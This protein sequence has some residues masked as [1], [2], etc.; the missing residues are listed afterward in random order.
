MFIDVL[1]HDIDTNREFVQSISQ[2]S[3]LKKH[4]LIRYQMTGKMPWGGVRKAVKTDIILNNSIRFSK[5][6]IGEEALYSFD[7]LY[8]SNS[9]GFIAS[10]VYRY[11]VRSGSLSDTPI[12]DPWG[13]VAIELRQKLQNDELYDQFSSTVNAFLYSA[14]AVSLVRIAKNYSG[15]EYRLKARNRIEQL[16]AE[17]D[18]SVEVDKESLS[19]KVKLILPLIQANCL[20][21]IKCVGKLK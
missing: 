7:V 17:L 16:N 5:Q 6:K 12:D 9:I 3:T 11:E 8:H 20:F 4:V 14:A 10:P 21:L 1:R 18:K 15:R 13:P 2:Y 19:T